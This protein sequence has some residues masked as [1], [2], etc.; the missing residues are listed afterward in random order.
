MSQGLIQNIDD[1]PRVLARLLED[2]ELIGQIMHCLEHEIDG[3]QGTEVGSRYLALNRIVEFMAGFADAS[4]HP[5]EDRV[6]DRLLHK[7]VSP[8][9]R[10]LVFQNLG[11]H[12]QI[13]AATRALQ[14][15]L[16]LSML[17]D[18]G[19]DAGELLEHAEAYLRQQR[20]HM[21]FE[22]T[23]LLP[24]AQYHLQNSDWNALA[25]ELAEA[26]DPQKHPENGR[27]REELDRLGRL[28]LA[29]PAGS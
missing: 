2:H 16:E 7:G 6:F 19:Q 28:I 20:R 9:E 12:Q 18:S 14:A 25:E 5:L 17:N 23:Q 10:H 15:E 4:H 27:Q 29:E 24:L 26:E 13:L 21:S 8:T 1:L 22:E 11:Q 3:L